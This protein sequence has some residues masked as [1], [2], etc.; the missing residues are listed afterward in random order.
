MNHATIPTLPIDEIHVE[1]GF[2]ARTRQDEKALERLA[3]SIARDGVIEPLLVQ[4]DESGRA[5]LIAG[6]RRLAASRIAGLEVVPV[7]TYE[8]ERPRQ[9]SLVE[10]FHR[11]DLDPIDAGRGLKAIA[12]EHNLTR[13]QLAEQID[14]SPSWVNARIRL[15]DLP[16]GVQE[17]VAEGTVPVEGE[18][19]LR[20]IAKVSPRIAECICI[21]AKRQKV[22]AGSFVKV[23][24]Q[25]LPLTS[26]GRFP[27]P[28]TMIDAER[29][30]ISELVADP[31][32]RRELTARLVAVSP[33]G[34]DDPFVNLSTDDLDAARAAGCLLEHE[35]DRGNYV[36]TLTYI[37]DA[38]F[39]TDLARR[40]VGRK[41]ATARKRAEE[42]AARSERGGAG[43]P[44]TPEEEKE[45]RAAARDKAKAASV[46]ARKFN[47]ELGLAL[48]KRRG[49]AT[50]KKHGLTRA[51][52][53][54]AVLLADNPDL[55]VR[56][57]RL[58]FTQL[59]EVEVKQLKSG[60]PREK[61]D[62]ADK[63]QCLAY[64]R[65]MV[66][67]AKTVDELLEVLA[68]TLIA[69]IV[70]DQDE[71]PQSR[72]IGWWNH[73]QDSV[74]K[75]LADDIKAVKPSRRRRK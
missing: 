57:L 54:A 64:V 72:R 18:R 63:E 28:P 44:S 45:S 21:T 59:Q 1:E 15:L 35:I 2:N 55:P 60:E 16:D 11:E 14:M 56:G 20:E 13:T 67:A 49:A 73:A 71:L 27:D 22:P 38:E 61:V 65:A 58:V 23:L 70:A 19:V 46:A 4:I 53:L 42:E 50:R 41:E 48:L 29:T 26:E 43:A 36:S 66:D 52:A 33:H 32:E 24:D 51:K 6:H 37:T 40:A 8:G 12:E 69:G 34:G 75:L 74:A 68:D 62:Y 17:L 10:N 9:V 3:A 7:T 39:A 47:G 25:L 31:T 30:T 5:K